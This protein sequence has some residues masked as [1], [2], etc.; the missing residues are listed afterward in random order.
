MMCGV[1]YFL[2]AQYLQ[3][4]HILIQIKVY[5]SLLKF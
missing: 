3:T 1:A 4:I 5:P 2:L